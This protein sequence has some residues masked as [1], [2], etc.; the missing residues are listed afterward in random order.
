MLELQ[1]IEIAVQRLVRAA[2]SP[3]K[4][5]LF[6]SYA[7]GR[8]DEGSDLHVLV[9]EREIPNM[10]DEYSRL[11]GAIGSIGTGVDVPIYPEDEFERRK[12]WQTSPVYD[13]LRNGKVM[14]ERA[15]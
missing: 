4:V 13:A 1:T 10:A 12:E 11:R 15:A 6:G 8:A 14:Y 7:T 2:H 5:I 9:I 3:I